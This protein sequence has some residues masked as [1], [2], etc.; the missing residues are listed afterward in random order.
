MRILFY[1]FFGTIQCHDSQVML[2]VIFYLLVRNSSNW[3][4]I[5]TSSLVLSNNRKVT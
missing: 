1:I 2:I 4:K 3:E 5:L